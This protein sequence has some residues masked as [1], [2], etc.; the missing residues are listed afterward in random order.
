[1]GEELPTCQKKFIFMTQLHH[2]FKCSC[3]R[4]AIHIADL[5]P[6]RHSWEVVLSANT[7]T[8]FSASAPPDHHSSQRG[9]TFLLTRRSGF[10]NLFKS[11]HSYVAFITAT[12]YRYYYYY[13]YY[14]THTVYTVCHTILQYGSRSGFSVTALS[15]TAPLGPQ[16][17]PAP[18]YQYYCQ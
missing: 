3:Y 13:R 18:L 8:S 5:L 14:F 16:Y 4:L 12:H 17:Y 1:M 15:S 9:R 10:F 6:V 2:L 11:N 7:S